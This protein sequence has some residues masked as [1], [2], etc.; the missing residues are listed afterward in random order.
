MAYR[1]WKPNAS[2]RAE[3]KSRMQ[4]PDEQAAYEQRKRERIEKRRSTSQFD[5]E[6]A[7]GM[8]VPTKA[9]HDFAVFDRRGVTTHIHIDACNQVAYGFSCN[10]KIHH[11]YIHIVN[12][13]M[14][15]ASIG[16]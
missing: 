16:E 1:K 10:E 15:T 2:Q 6:T 5:Y 9:Q 8:Y 7:G 14:R 3:F 12:E 11:D 4:D 13:L